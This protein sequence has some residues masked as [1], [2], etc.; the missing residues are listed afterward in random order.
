MA[1]N[2]MAGLISP[3][4]KVKDTKVN[5]DT[6]KGAPLRTKN[7]NTR[8]INCC[9]ILVISFPLILVTFSM[10]EFSHEKNLMILIP[11]NI[12]FIAYFFLQKIQLFFENEETARKT[13]DSRISNLKCFFL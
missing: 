11:E 1:G 9:L 4:S 13:F 12:S 3:P 2:T 7:R 8:T 5:K 6:S 10:Y